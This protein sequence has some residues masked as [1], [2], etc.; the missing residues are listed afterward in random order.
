[1]AA[2]VVGR[3]W[4]YLDGDPARE[5]VHSEPLRMWE[6][7]AEPE[8]KRFNWVEVVERCPVDQVLGEDGECEPWV[9]LSTNPVCTGLDREGTAYDTPNPERYAECLR[10]ATA[11]CREADADPLYCACLR[12]KPLV[13]GTN[14]RCASDNACHVALPET[15][16]LPEYRYM[17]QTQSCGDVP[18]DGLDETKAELVADHVGQTTATEAGQAAL[19]TAYVILGAVVAMVVALTLWVMVRE[20]GGSAAASRG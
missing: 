15:T 10:R 18:T 8:R 4:F 3:R 12:A 17:D 5:P 6:E 13:P 9:P 1:M 14:P 16:F 7:P 19:I 11:I 20:T 2:A